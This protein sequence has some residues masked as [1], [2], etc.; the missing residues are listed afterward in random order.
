MGYPHL[1]KYSA[2]LAPDPATRSEEPVW[3]RTSRLNI[4]VAEPWLPG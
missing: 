4:D 1:V 3:L 2:P